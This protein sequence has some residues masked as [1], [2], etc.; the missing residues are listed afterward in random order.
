MIRANAFL[1]SGG[2]FPGRT[3]R[4]TTTFQIHHEPAPQPGRKRFLHIKNRVRRPAVFAKWSTIAKWTAS[5][6]K[7]ATPEISKIRRTGLSPRGAPTMLCNF[8]TNPRDDKAPH[9]RRR[10]PSSWI[11]RG[12]PIGAPPTMVWKKAIGD[13]T[14]VYWPRVRPLADWSALRVL[15]VD[16]GASKRPCRGIRQA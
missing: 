2:R 9:P 4:G 12:R 8:A 11:R 7:S 10:G 3:V 13:G 14:T 5:A 6:K 15:P 16:S 1:F